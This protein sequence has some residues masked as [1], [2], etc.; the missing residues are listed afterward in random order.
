MPIIIR[1]RAWTRKSSRHYWVPHSLGVTIETITVDK[2]D[3]VIAPQNVIE[4]ELDAVGQ[5]SLTLT[6]GSVIEQENEPFTK[7]DLV[8]AGGSVVEN[9]GTPV[10]KSNLVFAGGL[11]TLIDTETTPVDKADLVIAG[12]SVTDTDLDTIPITKFNL[13]LAQQDIG[14]LEFTPQG[15][16]MA[17]GGG[18]GSGP[19]SDAVYNA[20]KQYEQARRDKEEALWKGRPARVAA[21]A[22]KSPSTTTAE[23]KKT[24]TSAP[25]P[26]GPDLDAMLAEML[27]PMPAPMP[28]PPRPARFYDPEE[29]VAVLLLSSII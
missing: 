10:D 3:L 8:I 29:D 14:S 19:A 12:K 20:R 27:A 11:V 6:G 22:Q 21:D 7:D 4:L 13:T 1:R 2:D 17:G 23:V 25:E 16:I 9:D 5:A 26:V 24:V 15:G 28:F 18:S